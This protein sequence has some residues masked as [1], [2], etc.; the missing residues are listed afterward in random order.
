MPWCP[1]CRT[2]YHEGIAGC[3]DCGSALVEELPSEIPAAAPREPE[4]EPPLEPE[5][6][7]LPLS[8]DL[9]SGPRLFLWSARQ[10]ARMRNLWALLFIFALLN[11]GLT[12]GDYREEVLYR[13]SGL[14]GL[15][16]TFTVRTF[17]ANTY[18]DWT[19][20]LSVAQQLPA[21][22]T[23][24]LVNSLQPLTRPLGTAGRRL[25]EWAAGDFHS[26]GRMWLASSV[27][28]FLILPQAFLTALLLGGLYGW[29]LAGLQSLA[30]TFRGLRRSARTHLWPLFALGLIMVAVTLPVVL[31]VVI[32][33]AARHSLE[34]VERLST[35]GTALAQ[36]PLLPLVLAPFAIVA[37]RSGVRAGI[38]R[39]LRAA[40][41]EWR[42]LLGVVVLFRIGYLVLFVADGLARY[43]ALP[44]LWPY[45]EI[46]TFTS[47]APRSLP[48][49][50]AGLGLELVLTLLWVA[51]QLILAASYFALVLREEAKTVTGSPPGPA[52][53]A[54]AG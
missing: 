16:P 45:R 27:P 44:H 43:G 2:E 42:T 12:L 18:Q 38:A 24:P 22:L 9:R 29:V 1:R 14:P 31:L 53:P 5:V 49:L 30:L 13:R 19:R 40:A 4:T 32:T 25:G 8:R 41:T 46:T 20:P 34:A 48:R 23:R 39:G 36:W 26:T 37:H 6:L 33:L 15:P 21:G 35:T 11:V 7:G 52:A 3:A 54:E 10:A 28:L 50:F 17:L 51:L 47:I